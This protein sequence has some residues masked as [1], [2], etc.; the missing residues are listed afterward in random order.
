MPS[1][2]QGASLGRRLKDVFSSSVLKVSLSL[3]KLVSAKRRAQFQ[4]SLVHFE[5]IDY[6]DMVQRVTCRP[7]HARVK[8]WK[9]EPETVDWIE[10]TI[11]AGDVMYDIGA[12]VGSYS[13]IAFAAS[14]KTATIIAFEPNPPNYGA[15]S[16]NFAE[17][18]VKGF[19]LP[20]ALSSRR[21]VVRLEG[22]LIQAGPTST[23]HGEAGY[24]VL[25]ERLDDLVAER[26]LP[27]PN[28]IKLDVDGAE[29]MVLEGAE[30]VLAH[31]GLRSIIFELDHELSDTPVILAWLESRGWT[32]AARHPR[33]SARF[34]NVILKRA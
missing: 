33:L 3:L 32:I 11:Q 18:H 28:L 5:A 7:E 21:E 6:K 26:S 10:A 17:N 2:S 4:G 13:L 22:D 30:G 19:V 12:N 20:V 27:L 23:T 34:E 31:S 8:G 1:G 24:T 15:A 29:K 9:K 14:G 25:A 16:A